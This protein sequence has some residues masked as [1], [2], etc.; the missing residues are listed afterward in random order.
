MRQN[1]FDENSLLLFNRPVLG[2]ISSRRHRHLRPCLSW[3]GELR[4]RRCTRCAISITAANVLEF[5]TVKFRTILSHGDSLFVGRHDRAKEFAN[6]SNFHI[7]G[8][9]LRRLGSLL[10]ALLNDS[11][12]MAQF[13]CGETEPQ[14]MQTPVRPF[15][16]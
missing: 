7:R 1:V 4:Q 11:D 3:H 16:S 9:E 2:E 15:N 5:F 12:L 6:V 13:S 10:A 14:K 8:T